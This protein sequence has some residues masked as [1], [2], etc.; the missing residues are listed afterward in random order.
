MA[1]VN[2]SSQFVLNHLNH[3]VATKADDN[4][5]FY[6]S[7]IRVYVKGNTRSP[8]RITITLEADDIR[9]RGFLRTIDLPE[10]FGLWNKGF[11]CWGD[12][13]GLLL[14]YHYKRNLLWNPCTREY[15]LLPKARRYHRCF[16]S[17]TVYG[18]VYDH[19]SN[20]YKV[21]Q[22]DYQTPGLQPNHVNVKIF[23]VKTNS[24]RSYELRIPRPPTTCDP[25]IHLNKGKCN[26]CSSVVVTFI[27][28]WYVSA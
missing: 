5:Q 7:S 27:P 16:S 22:V 23:S 12:C 2:H 19:S 28:G 1:I 13:H 4:E 24:W 25:A 21:V 17:S 15:K 9:G 20:D 18:F 6:G 14:L 8:T 10:E 11:R 3:H 26:L